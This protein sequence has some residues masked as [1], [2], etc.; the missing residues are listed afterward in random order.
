MLLSE[1]KKFPLRHSAQ[2]TR[3]TQRELAMLIQKHGQH[4]PRRA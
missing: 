1:V 2:L 3:L 4:M